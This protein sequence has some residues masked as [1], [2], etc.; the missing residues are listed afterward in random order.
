MNPAREILSSASRRPSGSRP[1]RSVVPRNVALA[2]A[3]FLIENAA[4]SNGD[5]IGPDLGLALVS[6]ACAARVR[7]HLEDAPREVR[8]EVERRIRELRGHG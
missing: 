2:H 6:E 5:M 4:R 1:S 7:A 8:A 3:E